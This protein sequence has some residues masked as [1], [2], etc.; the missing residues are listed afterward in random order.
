MTTTPHSHPVLA[1]LEYYVLDCIEH[2]PPHKVNALHNLMQQV[3]GNV[4]DWREALRNQL[5]LDA[6]IDDSIRV[7]WADALRIA[8]ETNETLTAEGFAHEF[9]NQNF[10]QLGE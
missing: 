10:A 3:F 8:K 9:V 6:K 2:L 4:K 5:G 7:M 1:M